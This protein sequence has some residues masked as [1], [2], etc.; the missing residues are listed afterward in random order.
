MGDLE[1]MGL[2]NRQGES[3]WSVPPDLVG[4]IEQHPA[5]ATPRHQLAVKKVPI[6]LGAQVRHEGPVWL[7]RVHL[8]NLAPY[9]FGA[10]LRRLVEQRRE[11]LRRAGIRHEDP[12][13]IAK[14]EEMERR[15]VGRKLAERSGQHC[16]D[17]PPPGYSGRVQ[18]LDRGDGSASYA[19][20]ALWTA[21]LLCDEKKVSPAQAVISP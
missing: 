9:G 14:L 16:L 8:E 11:G 2:V 7:D 20:Q 10:E 15:A 1:R 21:R 3:V 6:E 18:V 17:V 5:N 13:R 12:D 4:R 19:P